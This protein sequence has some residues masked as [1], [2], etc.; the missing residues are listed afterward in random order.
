MIIILSID[1]D[2]VFFLKL[3]QTHSVRQ[4]LMIELCVSYIYILYL[5][6]LLAKRDEDGHVILGPRN[7]TTK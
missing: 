2:S 5:F 1:R 3:H 4:I 7:F 6:L